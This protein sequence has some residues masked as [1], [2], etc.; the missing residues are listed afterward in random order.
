MQRQSPK[1]VLYY[2][3]DVRPKVL[4]EINEDNGSGLD[5]GSKKLVPARWEILNFGQYFSL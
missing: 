5:T 4:L 1:I 2:Q 3:K